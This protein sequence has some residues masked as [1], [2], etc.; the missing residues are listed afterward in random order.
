MSVISNA[1][2]LF[3]KNYVWTLTSKT[4]ILSLSPH[5]T[6]YQTA[7]AKRFVLLEHGLSE[8]Y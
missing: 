6:F 1:E 5:F 8:P 4:D 2:A 7:L 3:D